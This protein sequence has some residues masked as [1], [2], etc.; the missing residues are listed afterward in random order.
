MLRRR[1][2]SPG[3]AAGLR[4]PAIPGAEKILLFSR[5]YPVFPLD[6]NVLR[7]LL[8]LGYGK[9]EKS[10]SASYRSVQ[11]A[12]EAE[13]PKGFDGRIEAYQLLRRHGQLLCRRSHPLCGECPARGACAYARAL[14][15]GE[16]FP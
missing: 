9:Q 11:A 6:S 1:S 5:R 16:S 14:P 2:A 10:Y 7:V 4:G 15:S 13:L 3:L 12:V 8:R